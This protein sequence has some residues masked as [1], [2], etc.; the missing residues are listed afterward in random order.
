MKTVIRS[1][2]HVG[3]LIGLGI[4]PLLPVKLA[5]NPGDVDESFGPPDA[6]NQSVS[7]VLIQ[8]DRRVVLAGEFQSWGVTPRKRLLRLNPDGTL[9]ATFSAGDGP[10]GPVYALAIQSDGKLIIGGGFTQVSGVAR[11]RIARL[12]IDGSLDAG[13]DPGA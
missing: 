7:V 2:G 11:T 3:V 10:N 9:D 5:A 4:S 8:P 6:L 1:L 12:N 13:F